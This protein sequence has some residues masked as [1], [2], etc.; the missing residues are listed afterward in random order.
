METSNS[1]AADIPISTEL[2]RD[3]VQD[4]HPD[5]A[6]LPVRF[7][8]EGWDNTLYR[9]GSDLVVRLPRR[10]LAAD[11]IRH[12]QAWLPV[13]AERLRLPIPTPVRVG[14]PSSDLPYHWTICPWFE[15]S[16][17][18]ATPIR[19]STK[20]ARQVADFLRSLH[21]VAPADA[22]V[23]P[24]RGVP[25][26]HR[27]ERTKTCLER[28]AASGL[29][30]QHRKARIWGVWWEAI[31]AGPYPGPPVWLHGDLHPGNI[32][33]A[34]NE[35]VAVIDWGD[36]TSGDPACDLA[37]LWRLFDATRRSQVL[38]CL[39]TDSETILRARGW[40]LAIGVLL[41][42]ENKDRPDYVEL[43]HLSLREALTDPT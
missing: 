32:V 10:S 8:A 16:D 19:T 33:V 38:D 26:F 41:L 21:Q 36:I 34:N 27:H 31:T 42:V 25:L 22:P 2:V 7:V 35:I 13:L 11:L 15:G 39:G 29:L 30:D 40:A 23:N 4:Q 6:G 9:L 1:P 24:W 3:L 18:L 28:A 5:L 43:G 20:A 12:E 14:Q 37:L 17:A